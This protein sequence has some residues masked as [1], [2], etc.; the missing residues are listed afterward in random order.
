M[1][2]FFP[3]IFCPG[4]IFLTFTIS[5]QEDGESS[6]EGEDGEVGGLFRKVTKARPAKQLTQADINEM[7]TSRFIPLV[8]RDW[9]TDEVKLLN[10]KGN[11]SSSNC[12]FSCCV[13]EG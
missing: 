3:P 9:T 11:L 5:V 1:S 2:F 12:T 7:D 13:V 4:I 8:A 10:I 6:D